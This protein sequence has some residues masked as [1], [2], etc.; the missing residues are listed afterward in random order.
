[1]YCPMVKRSWLQPEGDV[2]NPYFGRKMPG[3]GNVVGN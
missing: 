1:M 2:G 3:C